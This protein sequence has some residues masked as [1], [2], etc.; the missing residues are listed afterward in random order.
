M[1]QESVL[2]E[3][4]QLAIWRDGSGAPVILVHGWLCDHQDLVGLAAQLAPD[5][6]TI[7]LDLRGHGRSEATH[8]EF[9]IAD[10]AGDVIGVIKA[11]E[12]GPVLLIGHSMGASVVLEAANQAPELV[13]GVVLIDSRWAF[14]SASDE[15]LASIPTLLGEAYFP[16]R[17]TMDGLRRKVLPDVEIGPPTQAVAA[18]AYAGMLTWPGQARLAECTVP[19]YAVVADQHWPLIDAA[20]AAVPALTAELITGT[21]HW[22]HVEQPERVAQSVRRFEAG[23]S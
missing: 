5:H 17:A 14:T 21:G 8:G 19:V 11:L 2:V 20:K 9:G 3:G 12:L 23:L 16:R 13:S 4:N 22:V 7:L 6:E 10:F 15:Q 1:T 18:A